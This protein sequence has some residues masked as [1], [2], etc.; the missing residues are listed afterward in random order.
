[1]SDETVLSC[2]GM[3]K[4]FGAVTALDGVDF[5]L[6]RGEVRA[7]L[8]KNGAGKSTLV[9]L[10][11][12]SLS[13]DQGEITL[14]GEKVQW[15]GPREAQSGGIAV[16]H[17]E[18]SL[19]PGLTVAE[20]ITMGRWPRQFGFV[21][22]GLLRRRA[23]RALGM[24]GVDIPLFVEVGKL[25]LAEQ[26]VVEIAKALVDDPK[27][28]ILDE[29]TSALN[30]TEVT[31][32]LKLVRRLAQTG[33]AV[34]YVSHRMKEIPLVADSLTV[35]RDGRHVATAAVSS[36]SSA[37]VAELISGDLEVNLEWT[38]RD[39]REA[40]VV[41]RID[42]LTVP[43]RLHGVSLALHE[44][45]VLG[46][47]GLLGSGRTELLE[48]VFGLHREA[49]GT[50]EV[51]GKAVDGRFP[52]KML[53][54]GVALTSED[55]K[56]AGIV[57][58][59]GVGENLMMTARGRILP[60]FWLRPLT[61]L[62]LMAAAIASLSIRASSPDQEIGTLSGGNQQKGVIGRA[63][64]AKMRILLL[65]EPTRGVDL[66]AKAQIYRLIRE[67]ADDGV[68]SIFVSSELEEIAEVCDRVLILRDGHVREELIGPEATAER[69]LALAMRQ[70]NEH[71]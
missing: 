16:V 23:E 30:N 25:S 28:L 64:T 41:L 60:P 39:R 26:Q 58:M 8:G 9:N 36:L 3:T 35:L 68:S 49:V 59:L 13:P 32:L 12:G 21:R 40:P 47:A 14:S 15:T 19:V 66:Q 34:I 42:D 4:R 69:I 61:E 62:R 20:N 11:S 6:K 57:P 37:Q 67:L 48:S 65:D 5:T 50:V 44:G 53:D 27:V 7:L 29:P 31:A 52:R 33:M 2:S 54:M 56:G 24:L 55:R 51:F 46:I 1:M 10:I 70:E 71:D 63:L 45:E 22:A 17:Q 18:F 43:H 38:H